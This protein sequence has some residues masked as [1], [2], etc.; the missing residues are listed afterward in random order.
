[1]LSKSSSG[2]GIGIDLS[3]VSSKALVEDLAWLSLDT[4]LWVQESL[5]NMFLLITTVHLQLTIV[6][7]CGSAS[8]SNELDAGKSLIILSLE[9]LVLGSASTTWRDRVQEGVVYNT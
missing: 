8:S 4:D 9:E 3:V 6:G 2:K 5:A 7:H 1:M